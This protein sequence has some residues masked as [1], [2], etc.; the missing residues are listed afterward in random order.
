VTVTSCTNA[1][2]DGTFPVTAG[3]GTTITVT[4]VAGVDTDATCVLSGFTQVIN[5]CA[6]LVPTYIA[7]IPTD[8]TTATGTACTGTF[9]TGYTIKA[10]SGRYTIAAPAAEDSATI[11]VTR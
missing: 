4:D 1:G 10:T 8:P 7:G 5:P 6:D 2:N 3:D 9:D 11:S